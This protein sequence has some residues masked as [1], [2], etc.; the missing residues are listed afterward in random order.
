VFFVGVTDFYQR[1][2]GEV[3]AVNPALV[4]AFSEQELFER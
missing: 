1:S 3:I 2:L 4:N